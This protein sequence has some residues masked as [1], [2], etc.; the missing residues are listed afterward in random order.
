MI[1]D[2]YTYTDH[3]D[4]QCASMAARVAP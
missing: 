1:S 3:W 2:G 4:D